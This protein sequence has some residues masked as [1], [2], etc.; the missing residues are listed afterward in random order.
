MGQKLL[1]HE[2]ACLC[3]SGAFCHLVLWKDMEQGTTFLCEDLIIGNNVVTINKC[4]ICHYESNFYKI[5]VIFCNSSIIHILIRFKQLACQQEKRLL[6]GRLPFFS[7]K[8]I[9]MYAEDLTPFQSVAGT[10]TNQHTLVSLT[11][12][13]SLPE[14]PH[15]KSWWLLLEEMQGILHCRT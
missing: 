5:N 1:A 9:K 11:T 12:H 13:G 4:L 3:F 6:R 2:M 10:E 8:N 15:L 7:W 14:I